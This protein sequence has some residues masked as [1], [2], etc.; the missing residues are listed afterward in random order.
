MT[1]AV[2]ITF[3]SQWRQWRKIIRFHGPAVPVF[4]TAAL[5]ALGAAALLMGFSSAGSGAPGPGLSPLNLRCEYTRA[6]LAVHSPHPRLSWVLESGGRNQ[7]QTAYRILVAGSLRSLDKGKGNLWDSGRTESRETLNIPYGGAALQSGQACFWKV[8]VWD[9]NGHPSQWSRTARWEMG[10]LRPSDWDAAW[11]GDGKPQPQKDEDFYTEDPA[12]L[13]RTEFGLRKKIASARLYITGLGYYEARINGRRVG[14]SVLDPGWT[15]FRKRVLYSAYDVTALLRKGQNCLGVMLGNGWFNPLPLR[16]WGRL[17]LREA[18]PVGRPRFIARLNIRFRDGSET[19]VRSG[20]S[21]KVAD[22]P[23]RRNNIYLGEVYD[24]RR[25]IAGWDKPGLDEA[26]WRPASVVKGPGG[27][28]EGQAQPPI[29]ITAEIKP[30][31]LLEPRPGVYIFDMGQNFAGWVR[32]KIRAPAGTKVLLRYGELL[33][34]DGTLN[35]LTS[36]CGQIKGLRKDGTPVG[37]PGAPEIADQRDTYIAAGGKGEAYVPAFTF[38]GFRYVEVTGLPARPRMG[39][40]TGLRLNAA[41]EEAGAFECSDPL[42]NSIQDMVRRTFLSNLFSVQSDC[43]QRERFGYG[44]DIGATSE[45]AMMNFDMASFY[46][47]AVRDWTDA[48][49]PGGMLTDTA[50]FVGIQYCGVAW[51]M[52]HPL[53]Q[54]QLYRYYGNRR[55][56]EDQ[57]NVSRAWLDLVAEQNPGLII[58]SGLSDHEG[59]APAPPAPMVTPLFAAS[60]G[61]LSRLAAI[62]GKEGDRDRFAVLRNSIR[63]A[64]LQAFL[65]PGT[66]RV[67]P[68]TQAGQAFA[69]YLDLL[70]PEEKGP[71]LDFLIQKIWEDGKGHLSTGI[72][73]T[74]FLLSVLSRSGRAELAASVVKQKDF[75]GWGFMLENGATTL[76]EHWAFSDNTFSHNHPMF[77]SVSEW[78]FQWLA[79]IQPGPEAVGFDRI[80]IRPQIVPGLDWVKASY[81]SVRGKISVHWRR[82][83]GR[84]ILHV[85]LPP[86]TK[87]VVFVPAED[88]AD[89]LESGIPASGRKGI[90]FVGKG[91]GAALF[92]VGSGDYTFVSPLSSS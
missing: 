83:N 68:G 20:P 75:P 88:E 7:V 16:M 52:V 8:M 26:G 78:F 4:R 5:L 69:L 21:W 46:A 33:N 84:L 91:P 34:D 11:I 30:A 10:L 6:P 2:H 1:P 18:L 92:A 86:N 81:R 31:A 77:G 90:R 79:G 13:F 55:L 28:L 44:G 80:I 35:P 24:A 58:E 82:K 74:K 14:E 54:A 59:L 17:N 76:W 47:K 40:M 51:A 29:K 38:H 36:V 64:Y 71:A 87:A 72:F 67:A 65:E 89:V 32:F 42:F 70:P 53:L 48:V 37:G 19:A 62:L 85:G 12:P 25:E 57:Y 9:K 3:S 61:L 56:I 49:L 73:G 15:N 27:R 23:I 39:D 41:V 60:A 45:A 22:G 63:K 50:P 66:G 43:P